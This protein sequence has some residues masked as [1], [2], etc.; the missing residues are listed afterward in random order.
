MVPGQGGDVNTTLPLILNIVALFCFCL[1]AIP[2]IVIAVQAG[3]ALKT[4]DIETAR[5]KAKLS[6]TL[7]VVAFAVGIL[8]NVAW[9][10]LGGVGA[11]MG[12]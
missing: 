12:N 5:A 10:V 4:G 6:L 1:V 3:N 2:G 9:F 7:A 11:V 8:A